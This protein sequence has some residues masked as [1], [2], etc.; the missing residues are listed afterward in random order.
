VVT[1]HPLDVAARD[2]D[3]REQIRL[4]RG[5]IRDREAVRTR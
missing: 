2:P 3:V 4:V 5:D 1:R